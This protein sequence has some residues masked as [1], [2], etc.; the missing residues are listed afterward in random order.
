MN[1]AVLLEKRAVEWPQRAALI[2][3]KRVI[4]FA[5][6]NRSVNRLANGLRDLGIQ[7]GDRV[8][9]M[10]PNTPEFVYSFFACQK[11]RAVAVP[12]NTLYKG[13]ELLYILR[14]CGAK[15]II[16]STAA[17]PLINEIKPALPCLEHL[18][19]TGERSLTF[20]HPQST[21]FLQGVLARDLFG[22]LDQAYRTV[23]DA[24]AD[25]LRTLGLRDVWYKHRGSLRVGSRKVAAFYFSEIHDLY[26][27]N[28]IC[29]LAPFDP[30]DFF[31]VIWVPPEMRDKVLEPLRSIQEEIGRVP[32]TEEFRQTVI[33]AL[34]SALGVTV[35]EGALTAAERRSFK[36]RKAAVRQ[37]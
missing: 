14:D 25:A 21:I 37:Q 1:L 31:S 29:F 12:V 8:A 22:T 13:G 7:R 24:L 34:E 9:I 32:R 19:T 30:T 6:L 27:L 15:T 10:L 5:E 18:I 17:I 4:T 20:A 23:G 11:L 28:M 2:Y 3:G 35:E 33:S 16:T 26:I 36:K